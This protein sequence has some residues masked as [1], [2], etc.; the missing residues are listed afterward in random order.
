[1]EGSEGTAEMFIQQAMESH[2]ISKQDKHDWSWTSG[3]NVRHTQEAEC[4]KTESKSVLV[5]ERVRMA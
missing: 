2:Y 4:K 5:L 3:Q 1:M